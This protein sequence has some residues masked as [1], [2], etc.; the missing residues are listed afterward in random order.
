VLSLAKSYMELKK[1][2]GLRNALSSINQRV[3]FIKQAVF[4]FLGRS[5]HSEYQIATTDADI[6]CPHITLLNL[7]APNSLEVLC[8]E[9]GIL[10]D[11]L[12]PA[13]T[14]T[15]TLIDSASS[16]STTP[17][18]TRRSSRSSNPV[19]SVNS[20]IPTRELNKQDSGCAL[21]TEVI[22]DTATIA[23]LYQ[24][25]I[26]FE[27]EMMAQ[28]NIQVTFSALSKIQ[29]EN[30]QDGSSIGC[31]IKGDKNRDG[32]NSDDSDSNFGDDDDDDDKHEELER[33]DWDPIRTIDNVAFKRLLLM[34]VDPYNTL[35]PDA[36]R[37]TQRIEGAYHHVVF[38][39][40]NKGALQEHYYK[41][42]SRRHGDSLATG[43]CA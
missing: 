15:E 7:G 9:V 33:Q 37:I 5:K 21:S 30:E 32:K 2:T 18:N 17:I 43:R 29:P 10:K 25:I 28:E 39:K 27:H 6:A 31:K 36:C 20:F 23:Q 41:N 24:P 40:L 14:Q 26:D 16:A 35:P 1:Q 4:S 3:G 12:A 8:N 34:W 19:T 22:S 42:A 13:S 38:V 11:V